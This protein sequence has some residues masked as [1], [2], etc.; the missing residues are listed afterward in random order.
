M[1]PPV[2]QNNQSGKYAPNIFMEGGKEVQ[3]DKIHIEKIIT[4]DLHFISQFSL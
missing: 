2:I 1:L 4:S 3:P